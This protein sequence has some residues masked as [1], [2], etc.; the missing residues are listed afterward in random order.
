MSDVSESV[1]D[2]LNILNKWMAQITE[3]GLPQISAQLAEIW[4][5]QAKRRES[6]S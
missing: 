3:T 5:E 2:E 1:A 6:D 4:G